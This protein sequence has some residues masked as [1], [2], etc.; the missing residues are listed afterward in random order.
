MSVTRTEWAVPFEPDGRRPGKPV[1][2]WPKRIRNLR[3]RSG[4]YFIRDKETEEVLYVGRA[5]TDLMKT[6]QRHFWC[7]SG[8]RRGPHRRVTYDRGTVEVRVNLVPPD[9]VVRA[10]AEA[11]FR[12]RPRDNSRPETAALGGVPF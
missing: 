6:L 1:T 8:D 10:E 11:I 3:G 7:W 9:Q 4:I 12:H 5:S 2:R